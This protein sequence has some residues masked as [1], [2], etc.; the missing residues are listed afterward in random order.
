MIRIEEIE[1]IKCPGISSFTVQIGYDPTLFKKLLSIPNAIYHKKLKKFEFP[2]ASLSQLIDLLIEQNDITMSFLPSNVNK[3]HRKPKLKYRT[4]PYQYQL[5]GIEFG[6]NHDNFLLLDT[7]GLGKTIQSILLAEELHA[8]GEVEHCLIVCGINILKTNWEK[9]IQK[10]SRLSSF[11]VGKKVSRSGNVSFQGIQ[12]RVEQLKQK[13]DDF[14]VIINIESLRSD[15]IIDAINNGPNK[16]DMIIFDECHAI[17]DPQAQWTKGLLKLDATHKVGMTGT[18]LLNNPL[19]LYVPLKW[20]GSEKAS[21]TNFRYYYCNYG[22]PFG[23]ELIGYKNLDFLKEQLQENSIRRTKD[24]LDLPEKNIIVEYVDMDDKQQRFYSNVKQGI[25]DQ[26]DKVKLS[27]TNLLSMVTR[28]RQA[29]T[30]P[31][32]LTSEDI[33]SAKIDRTV[34]L[35]DEIVSNGSKVVIFSVYKETVYRLQQLLQKYKP[36]IGTG[37][38]SDDEIS[39]SI[40]LFQNNEEN[41][42]FIGTFS[43]CATGITLTKA[44]YM[45]CVDSCWTSAQNLQAEDRIHRIGSKQPV[46][47]YYLIT[48]NTID[49]HVYDIVQDKSIISEYIVD[50]QIPN[51]AYDKLKKI[52]ED[53]E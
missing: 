19:E 17:K 29:T 3:N 7:P 25:K 18:I 51:G 40:D 36:L 49:T 34:G 23:N 41:R 16:F 2:I 24:L 46:F 6:L 37:D 22:G 53:L 21:Y 28:L 31:S 8:L 44:N 50:N 15:E 26:V 30:C 1:T 13:I 48:N 42:V 39:K 20:I 35:V 5:E 32:V 11:L 4:T 52:M 10:H 38:I 14:F 27:A 47:I 33:P 43:K 9:E 45:I 12:Y